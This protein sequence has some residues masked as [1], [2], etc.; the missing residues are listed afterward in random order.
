[1][2]DYV[3]DA[4]QAFNT[5]LAQGM[6]NSARNR[7]MEIEQYNR[8]YDQGITNER[9]RLANEENN[10]Q[11]EELALRKKGLGLDF[12]AKELGIGKAED[13]LDQE[14]SMS[15]ALSASQLMNSGQFSPQAHVGLLKTA[16]TPVMK[17]AGPGM[18]ADVQVDDDGTIRVNSVDSSGYKTP[19]F[20]MSADQAKYALGY[21]GNPEGRRQL[22]QHI[23]QQPSIEKK[24]VYDADGNMTNIVTEKRFNLGGMPITA[25]VTSD[26]FAAKEF[27]THVNQYNTTNARI[28]KHYDDLRG[29]Q[30]EAT[31]MRSK[32]ALGNEFLKLGAMYSK[33]A[34]GVIMDD[35]VATKVAGAFRGAIENV[36]DMAEFKSGRAVFNGKSYIEAVSK[37]KAGL[38]E[39]PKNDKF[40]TLTPTQQE[41]VRSTV[42][43]DAVAKAT[44]RK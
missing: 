3:A 44:G 28:N 32:E 29:A 21:L 40:K 31:L 26:A 16:F 41:Q 5:G 2:R 24:P 34:G 15:A 20:T 17:M 8:T 9:I 19:S 36:Q 39:L 37:A 42:I 12:K 1:M 35:P 25:G 6:D 23:E 18:A 38:A 11:N 43:N 14:R 22:L 4:A 7:Q 33:E 30:D 10:R 13:A 27:Q